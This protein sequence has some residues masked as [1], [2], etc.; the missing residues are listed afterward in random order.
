MLCEIHR[1]AWK[2][3]ASATLAQTTQSLKAVGTCLQQNGVWK[4][5][6]DYTHLGDLGSS[7]A[8]VPHQERASLSKFLRQ[9]QQVEQIIEAARKET[10]HKRE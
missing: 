1:Y 10:P 4:G 9:K 8:G 5:A 7:T 3:D 6:W 2:G